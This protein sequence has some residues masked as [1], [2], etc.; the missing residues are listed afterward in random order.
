MLIFN[1]IDL[2]V[3]ST[4]ASTIMRQPINETYNSLGNYICFDCF[5]KMGL[6]YA[7]IFAIAGSL[8]IWVLL[9]YLMYLKKEVTKL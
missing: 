5:S 6:I 2:V 9:K 3:T 8:L 1:N 4:S 7:G